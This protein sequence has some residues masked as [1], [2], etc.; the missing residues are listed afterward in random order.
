MALVCPSQWMADCAKASVLCRQWPVRCIANPL[1]LGLW[2]P[3]PK[4][5]ARALLNLPRDKKIVLF[6]AIGG[7]RDARKGADLLR[8]ALSALKTAVK[9]IHLVVFGQSEPENQK[10]FAYPVTYLGRFQ[11]EL[12][13]IAIYNS[14]DVMLVPSRQDNLP[15]TAVE[16]QAC[17][18][19]VVAFEVGG[20][21]DIVTHQASGYLAR[22]FDTEDFARGVAE[23]LED[24][25]R[26][27]QM[28][29]EA[30]QTAE[31]KFA[32]PVVA[33]AYEELYEQV[34]SGA[35]TVS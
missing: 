21:A 10:P 5:E 16:A 34:L 22:P 28:T 13:M 11:D 19:P 4:E 12:S 2:K 27:Q 26:Y 24:K 3:F 29:K 18:I 1:D 7:E 32:A 8:E 31:D 33:K 20:L 25:D 17:G 23:L 30:R 9:D 35:V 6:G 14:A 15:Q